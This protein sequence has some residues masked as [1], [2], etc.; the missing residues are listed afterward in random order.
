MTNDVF[1]YFLKKNEPMY[2]YHSL[3]IAEYYIKQVI[4][5]SDDANEYQDI[6][7]IIYQRMRAEYIKMKEKEI[8]TLQNG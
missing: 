1:Y 4:H 7:T 8:K 2:A 3:L 6:M 5:K